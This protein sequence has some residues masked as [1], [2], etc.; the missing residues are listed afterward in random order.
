MRG[1]GYRVIFKISSLRKG[2][3][4]GLW[5][6]LTFKYKEKPEGTLN[7]SCPTFHSIVYFVSSVAVALS[8]I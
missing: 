6:L 7:V 4:Y 2:L 8:F 3:K 5:A 1:L